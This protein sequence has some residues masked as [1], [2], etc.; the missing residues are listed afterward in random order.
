MIP[1]VVCLLNA[2]ALR[3]PKVVSLWAVRM[4]T[5]LEAVFNRID[6]QLKIAFHCGHQS[7]DTRNLSIK[8]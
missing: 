7:F 3:K 8:L 6:F 2:K 5:L 4:S 1:T